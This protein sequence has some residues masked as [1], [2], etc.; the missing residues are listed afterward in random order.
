MTALMIAAGNNEVGVVE[1]LIDAGADTH[2]QTNG[3]RKAVDYARSNYNLA[4]TDLI[5][6]LE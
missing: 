4:Y 1:A 3:G 6:R 2:A 5:Y